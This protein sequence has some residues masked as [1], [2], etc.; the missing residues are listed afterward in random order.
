MGGD[1]RIK[2]GAGHG[3]GGLRKAIKAAARA[4]PRIVAR[5]KVMNR[6]LQNRRKAA[7]PPDSGAGEASPG[8]TIM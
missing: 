3:M 5:M 2:L 7:C 1:Q 6:A 8:A 4:D